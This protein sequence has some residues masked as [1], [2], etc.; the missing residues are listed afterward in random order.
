MR[1]VILFP[2]ALICSALVGQNAA[3]ESLVQ[4][5]NANLS[6]V[7]Q[8]MNDLKFQEAMDKAQSL[9]PA[10]SPVFDAKDGKVMGESLDNGRGFLALLKLQ[11]STVAASGQWEKAVEVNQKRV[12]Y[13]QSLQKDVDKA[14]SD[15][16][17]PWIKMV[18]EGKA[19]IAQNSGRVADLEKSIAKLQQDIKDHNEKKV[20]LE[21]KQLEEIQKVRIPQAQKDEQ[22][23]ADIKGKLAGYQ[24][25]LKRYPAFQ[26]LVAEN[27]KETA[28]MVKEAGEGLEKVKTLVKSRAEEI[29]AFNAKQ[30]D[31]N[32][33]NKKFKID[34][35]KN[36]VEAVMN[37]KT[38]ITNLDSPRAQAQALNRLLVEDP[39]SKPAAAALENLKAGRE[40]FPASK[41]KKAPKK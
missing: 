2:A 32:K 28:A 16:E 33:K 10:Q 15:L 31:K 22:E 21:K 23:V 5:F 27:R 4:R 19:Y 24:D 39:G 29:A 6:A 30:L 1:S 13:A 41:S 14:M 38:N 35:N 40:P 11:A 26:N 20:V 3:S 36:W 9:L 34:G 7:N 17:A 25:A 8:L 12:D 18:T 37:D